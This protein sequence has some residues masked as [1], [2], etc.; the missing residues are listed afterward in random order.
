MCFSINA[1]FY[2]NMDNSESFT[3]YL[4]GY[5]QNG[6]I[7]Q[8]QSILSSV[9]NRIKYRFSTA[10]CSPGYF[11]KLCTPCPAGRFGIKLMWRQVFS[12]CADEYCDHVKGCFN[13]TENNQITAS[14]MRKILNFKRY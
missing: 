7:Y 3:F 10:A 1:N 11:G 4:Q 14:G 2:P 13:K 6:K 5:I 8:T 12:K 9:V